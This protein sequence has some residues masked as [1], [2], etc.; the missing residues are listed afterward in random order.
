MRRHRTA[1]QGG[2][3]VKTSTGVASVAPGG[4]SILVSGPNLRRMLDISA[5][6]LWRWRHDVNAGFPRARLINGRLYFLWQEVQAWLAK[7]DQAA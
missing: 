5:V 4:G 7:Q 3:V 1:S 2:R 6:T